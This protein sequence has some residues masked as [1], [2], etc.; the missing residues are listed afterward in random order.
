VVSETSLLVQVSCFPVGGIGVT[1]EVGIRRQVECLQ[2]YRKRPGQRQ[3]QDR[4]D[5]P[6]PEGG[7]NRPVIADSRF[8]P[9]TCRLHVTWCLEG[10]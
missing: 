4:A 5:R 7:G 9:A 2:E 10:D 8:E 6:D 3:L 1:N